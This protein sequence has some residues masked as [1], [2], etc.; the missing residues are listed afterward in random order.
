MK[1][2]FTPKLDNQHTIRVNFNRLFK[3]IVNLRN[4]L[5]RFVTRFLRLYFHFMLLAGW[6]LQKKDYHALRSIKTSQLNPTIKSNLFKINWVFVRV[7]NKPLREY[8]YRVWAT[9]VI[10]LAITKRLNDHLN[11]TRCSP[12]NTSINCIRGLKIGIINIYKQTK[13]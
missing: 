11:Y 3:P 2:A 13:I 1:S 6:F 12:T 8:R 5:F 9:P 7:K 10:L 4:F